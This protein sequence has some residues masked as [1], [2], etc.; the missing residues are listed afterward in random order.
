MVTVDYE[1]NP[2]QRTPCVL[3]L[4]ASGSMSDLTAN[5]QPRIAQVNLGLKELARCL[6]ED[7]TAL[8]RVILSIVVVGGPT[9]TAEVLMDWTDASQFVPF[10]LTAD[11]QTPLAQGLLL[12]LDLIEQAKVEMRQSGV[13]YTR[14]WMMVLTDGEPTDSELWSRAVQACQ[15][16]TA[17]NKC[18]IYPIGVEGANMQTLEQIAPPMRL[19]SV[20]F[21]ELFVWL[22]KSLSTMSRSRPGDK[23]QLPSTSP[24]AAVTL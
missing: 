9:G 16:A 6:H 8:S 1:A 14:P 20:K 22:S 18:Q 13:S 7:T 21:K 24:W 4:D 3:I 23:I 15:A 17:G 19:D 12:G 10:E 5:G 2:N 11:N